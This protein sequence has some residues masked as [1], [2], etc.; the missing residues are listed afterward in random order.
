MKKI[1]KQ[2]LS[3]LRQGLEETEIMHGLRRSEMQHVDV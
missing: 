1:E 3:D 2:E